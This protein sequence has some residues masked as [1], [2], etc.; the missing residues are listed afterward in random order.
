MSKA[1]NRVRDAATKEKEARERD[2]QRIKLIMD[3]T[4]NGYVSFESMAMRSFVY[5]EMLVDLR[6]SCI[7][8]D[9]IRSFRNTPMEGVMIGDYMRDLLPDED[10][11]SS[12]G[13]NSF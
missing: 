6:K 7:E 13:S 3:G 9:H 5:N 4:I 2:T 8:A 1:Q 10:E 12:S 11:G